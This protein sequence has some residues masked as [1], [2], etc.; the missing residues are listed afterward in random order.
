MGK[1]VPILCQ[2]VVH[3]F[4]RARDLSPSFAS[5][6]VARSPV[7]LQA[8]NFPGAGFLTIKHCVIIGPRH[9]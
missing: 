1:L 4:A 3:D 2:L 9:R 8:K 5:R 6:S 7:S